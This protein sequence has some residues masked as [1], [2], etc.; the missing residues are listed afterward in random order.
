MIQ[1]AVLYNYEVE[2]TPYEYEY[3][4]QWEHSKGNIPTIQGK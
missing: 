1:A 4:L 2:M 3:I